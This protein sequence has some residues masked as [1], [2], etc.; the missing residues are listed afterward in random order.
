[1]KAK[2]QTND[3]RDLTELFFL[4]VLQ[5]E[6]AELHCHT[7]KT[8]K[9]KLKMHC[10]EDKDIK[11]IPFDLKESNRGHLCPAHFTQLGR[12]L[13][14]RPIEEVDDVAEPAQ[15]QEMSPEPAPV[16]E[17]I[18]ESQEEVPVISLAVSRPKASKKGAPPQA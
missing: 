14:K 7:K 10:I 15:S 16:E 13:K 17:T 2:K 11:G 18:P 5:V 6:C 9:N 4:I 12:L 8:P 1:M 3:P